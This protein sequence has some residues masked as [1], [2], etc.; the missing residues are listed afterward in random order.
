M[1]SG[2]LIVSEPDNSSSSIVQYPVIHVVVSRLNRCNNF[3]RYRGSLPYSE[4]RTS[5]KIDDLPVL[6]T[7]RSGTSPML[8][9][10]VNGPIAHGSTR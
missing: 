8:S 6:A 5:Q 9:S 3:S 7:C 10:E 2:L 1:D 4:R